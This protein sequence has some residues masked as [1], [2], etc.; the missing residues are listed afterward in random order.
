MRSEQQAKVKSA[1]ERRPNQLFVP[2]VMVSKGKKNNKKLTDI[3][4]ERKSESATSDGVKKKEKRG[5]E[6]SGGGIADERVEKDT[7]MNRQI[8]R[9]NDGERDGDGPTPRLR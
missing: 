4:T 7:E 3:Y 1:D 9:G 6:A 5:R 8:G 2:T